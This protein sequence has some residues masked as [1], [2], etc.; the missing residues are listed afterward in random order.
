M[1]GKI[2]IPNFDM[3]KLPTY[4]NEELTGKKVLII[5][6]GAVGSHA[7]SDISQQGVVQL[8][9]VDKDRFEKTN[10]AK[11]SYVYDPM[12]DDGKNKA[13]ALAAGIN[14]RLGADF[15]HGID[16]DIA[17]FGPMA[18][19]EYDSII[20][21]LDNYGAKILSNHIWLQVPKERRPLMIF[22]GTIGASAQSNCLDGSDACIR[23]LFDESWLDNPFERYSCTGINYGGDVSDFSESDRTTG[24]ASMISAALIE[25][26]CVGYLLGHNGMIN[27]RTFYN[28]F[29]NQSLLM[30]KPLRRKSCP[31]CRNYHSIENAFSLK[32]MDVLH[33]KVRELLDA[34]KLYFSDDNFVV[35]PQTY[36]PG[37]VIYNKIIKNDFCRCCGK[38][39]NKLYR[40][41]YKTKVS[42][43][44]CTECRESGRNTEERYMSLT[45][46]YISGI[47]FDNCDD[48]L[49]EKTLF[50]VG[51]PVGALIKVR[52]EIP[53][54][55]ILDSA[56]AYNYF[57]CENDP[58]LLNTVN[59]LEE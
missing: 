48:E 13:I 14:H 20:L 26:D 57:Y 36:E 37:K 42:D 23:C 24:G 34:I 21:A 55:S 44:V 51:F 52:R 15:V 7:A 22:G 46:S 12:E 17:N 50:E 6:A 9:I 45:G 43:L 19:A 1:E 35:F 40:H 31:D 11:S 39:L 28:S 41:E 25:E 58:K 5:G 3:R 32:D 27:R 49:S 33:T 47:S 29:P 38:E 53:G 18:F 10:I 56:Y 8:T 54:E 59:K 2:I 16:S 4:V 30:S